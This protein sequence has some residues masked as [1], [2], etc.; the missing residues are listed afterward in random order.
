MG[1]RWAM[2]FFQDIKII[3]NSINLCESFVG[4]M[5]FV[6]ENS[7]PIPIIQIIKHPKGDNHHDH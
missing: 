4:F 6:V 2:K 1:G 7:Y 5:L 3:K